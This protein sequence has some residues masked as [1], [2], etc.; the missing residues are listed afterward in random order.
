MSRKRKIYAVHDCAGRAGYV[1]CDDWERARAKIAQIQQQSGVGPRFKKF[2]TMEDAEYFAQRGRLR[3]DD[4]DNVIYTDGSAL[5]D[6]KSGKKRAGIG[7]YF[8]RGSPLNLAEAFLKPPLTNNRAELYAIHR[9]I[10]VAEENYPANSEL[11]ILTDSSYAR[12]ALGKW[13]ELWEQS[14]FRD[15][16]IANRDL[17]EPLWERMDQSAIKWTLEWVSGHSG[18]QGNEEADRLANVG[19]GFSVV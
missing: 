2:Q 4:R 3:N 11:V 9:A 10:E 16:S 5:V 14:N 17:I 8:G 15:N 1:F 18:V 6:A 12:D 13:R 7:V 19:A